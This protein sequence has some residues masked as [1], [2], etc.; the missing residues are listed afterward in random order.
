MWSLEVIKRMNQPKQ[1]ECD[2]CKRTVPADEEYKL[3][4]NKKEKPSKTPAKVHT[5]GEF[6]IPK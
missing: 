2:V 6:T 4:R 1:V 5:Y 3:C